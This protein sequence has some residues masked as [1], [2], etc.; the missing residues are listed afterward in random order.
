MSTAE[1]SFS[2]LARSCQVGDGA[3]AFKRWLASS[4]E[5]W[6]LVLDNADDTSLDIAT[7]FPK[8]ARGA[9]ILTTRNP[10]CIVHNT[11]GSASVD[12]MDFDE[13]TTLLLKASGADEND[14]SSRGRAQPVIQLLGYLP[15]AI[16]QAGAAIRQ[17]LYTYEEYHEAFTDRRKELL[18][19]QNTQASADYRY[20]VYAAW[21]VSVNAIRKEARGETG[22]P[23]TASS[24]NAANALDLLTVFGFCYY[25][26]ILEDIW[27]DVWEFF[28]RIE[29]NRWWTSNVIRMFR[30]DQSPK[31][32]PLPFRQAITL[33]SKY[34]LVYRTNRRIS[35]HP[36]VH[37]WIRDSLDDKSHLQWWTTT[38][39]ML[40]MTAKPRD[41][42]MFRRQRL[43]S[44]H[45]N[46]CLKFRD[47]GDL[48]VEDDSAAART[49]VLRRLSNFNWPDVDLQDRLLLA[50][51]TVEY[52]EKML[53]QDDP[54]LWGFLDSTASK[55]NNLEQ[56]QTTVDLLGVK[57]ISYLDT[58]TLDF[59]YPM[60]SLD[61]MQRLIKAYRYVG[62]TQE[63]LE[64]AE[65]VLKI[66]KESCGEDREITLAI[67]ETM[68]PIYYDLGRKEMALNM[69]QTVYSKME[70]ALGEGNTRCLRAKYSLAGMH[71]KMGQTQKALNMYQQIL[72]W[73]KILLPEDHF[74]TLEAQAGLAA[75]YTTLGRPEDGIPLIVDALDKGEKAG[76]LAFDMQRWR[77]YLTRLR[78][79]EA[80]QLSQRKGQSAKIEEQT[81]HEGPAAAAQ[82]QPSAVTER[83]PKGERGFRSGLK[84][85]IGR[86]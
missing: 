20:T 13:A 15:L 74:D 82:E 52:C 68:A 60:A 58:R 85:I 66:C 16:I 40:A 1:H 51:R 73:N 44:P 10:D 75:V 35:L 79:M 63:A 33:L 70:A 77:R 25:E 6:L 18:S 19:F 37:S 45:L 23:Q 11:V 5:H 65:K 3:E 34:S 46:A 26:D 56:W 4:T 28:P 41:K 47:F 57:V 69:F 62:R 83:R 50:Q 31:W 76:V 7:F 29:N 42:E 67:E 78:A 8:G 48:L 84:K 17:E 24:I 71:E 59:R 38:L 80:E 39:A 2:E 14:Q 32:D 49:Q 30:E 21:D 22:S 55:A 9:I 54:R 81:Q 64:L 27:Q 36:L 43:L 12:K 86:K 61:A 72:E 53:D